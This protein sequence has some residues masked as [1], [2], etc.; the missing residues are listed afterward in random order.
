MEANKTLQI[1]GKYKAIEA[2]LDYRKGMADFND[3]WTMLTAATIINHMPT[4]DAVE[5]V[6][7]KDCVH[8][9]DDWNGNQPMFTCEIAR[10]GESVQPNDYCSYGERRTE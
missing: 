1:I 4:I 5:V 10:C 7:C 3:K 8:C 9:A 2:L 6:R